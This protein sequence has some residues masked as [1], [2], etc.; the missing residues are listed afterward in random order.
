MWWIIATLRRARKR[1]HPTLEVSAIAF[2]VSPGAFWL[3]F[4]AAVG[5]DGQRRVVA[6]VK[7]AA[8]LSLR[9]TDWAEVNERIV[10][11]ETYAT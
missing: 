8:H 2:D 5:A 7:G 10:Y 9:A 1:S 4:S 3:S 11:G 6:L